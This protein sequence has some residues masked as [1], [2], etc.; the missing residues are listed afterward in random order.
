[1][2]LCPVSADAARG[3][4]KALANNEAV[5]ILIDQNTTR[6]EGIFADFFGIPAATTPGL[7]TF[8]LRTD[9]AVVP[10]FIRWDS[11]QQRHVL[12]FQPRL[13][14]IRSGDRKADVG[15][16][17]AWQTP[18]GQNP[19]RQDTNLDSVY[20]RKPWHYRVGFGLRISW[21]PE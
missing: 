16:T 17:G 6:S 2:G 13:D 7:A 9:A 5:G 14:L 3:V 15:A 19:G 11:P 10:G 4:L 12:E 18:T 20:E 21:F 8:A 1:M